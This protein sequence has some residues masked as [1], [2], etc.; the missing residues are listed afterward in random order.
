MFKREIG[1]GP[2][3]IMS[4]KSIREAV[5]Y[6]DQS[7]TLLLDE[8]DKTAWQCLIYDFGQVIGCAR[9]YIKEDKYYMDKFALLTKYRGKGLG[10]DAATGLL[11]KARELGISQIFVE[12]PEKTLGFYKN[13]GFKETLDAKYKDS[14]L[15]LLILEL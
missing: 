13:L 12:A 1:R 10:K 9:L 15:T 4:A 14:K 6:E 5:Y 11:G 7:T 3:F 2:L 8:F